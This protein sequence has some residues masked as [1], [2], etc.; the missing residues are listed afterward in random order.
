MR[1][2]RLPDRAS[3]KV[4]LLQTMRD[5]VYLR[6]ATRG[7]DDLTVGQRAAANMFTLAKIYHNGKAG[8]CGEWM[9]AKFKTTKQRL[10]VE[11]SDFLIATEHKRSKQRGSLVKVLA[12][13]TRKMLRLHMSLPGQR[14]QVLLFPPPRPG[15]TGSTLANYMKRWDIV[16]FGQECH[17]GCTL[18]R[19]N[20][21]TRR[22]EQAQR[23]V[24]L[25]A[26]H[27]DGHS[28]A[29]EERDYVSLTPAKKAVLAREA[30]AAEVDTVAWL[31]EEQVQSMVTLFFGVKRKEMG[32]I[33]VDD[34]GGIF[35][36]RAERA[37]W[38][39]VAS[40]S[41]PS[42]RK[43]HDAHQQKQRSAA[44]GGSA[45]SC[46]SRAWSSRCITKTQERKTISFHHTSEELGCLP[47]ER[48]P[49]ELR[50]GTHSPMY[51]GADMDRGSALG[52]F[53]KM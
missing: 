47:T 19:K 40:D 52:F 43:R 33:C 13:A 34:V 11:K 48:L 18:F 31:T 44:S 49:L 8:R 39:S 21:A 9:K 37:A 14:K 36:D 23:Q 25:N 50:G 38:Q 30:L 15:T 26:C 10:F 17:K 27:E 1:L 42:K 4:A 12:P 41:V 45:C 20:L 28:M 24:R 53:L 32:S 29:V 2:E 16:H 5:M 46:C 22:F 51:C 6:A 7:Q 35:G 3:I